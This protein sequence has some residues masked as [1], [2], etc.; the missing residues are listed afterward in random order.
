[1]KRILSSLAVLSLAV[2]ATNAQSVWINEVLANP[3]GAD[4]GNEYF[5]LRGTPNMSLAGYY[6]LSL[7]GQGGTGR[8]DINQFFDLGAFSIGA[9]GYLFA[10][11]YN[12]PHGPVAPGAT[13]ME[14]TIEP[15]W[16]QAD[17]AGSS[18]G[19]YSDGTQTDLEN[20]A[21]TIML[22]NIGTGP[23]PLTTMDLD[24]DN[25]GF[26]DL[27]EGWTVVD[28]IGLIDGNNPQA[29]D[30]SY[31]A[32]TFRAPN[33]NGEY[34]GGSAYGNVIDLP[35]SPP[36]TA[37]ALYVGRKGESTGSTADDW[38]GAIMWSGNILNQKFDVTTDPF[39]EGLQYKDMV[40]GGPN[41]IPEP[42]TWALLGLGGLA[43][44]LRRPKR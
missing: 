7:E 43:Y 2:S 1:M 38:F 34:F 36:T 31:G 26:L 29:S 23:V 30:Y 9:N 6:L 5:E 33:N 40:Y 35:G 13:L 4:G 14:N 16:G 3:L 18:V 24:T 22:V 8:G 20:S 21:T 44:L 32:I 17:G 12:S 10:R 25:D 19:H 27:P 37:G 39:Y 41:P 11:Q 42:G 15:G 28:S